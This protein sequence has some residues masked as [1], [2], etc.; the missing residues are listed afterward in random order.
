MILIFLK[1]SVNNRCSDMLFVVV[2]SLISLIYL[3]GCY[4]IL[5]MLKFNHCIAHLFENINITPFLD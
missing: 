5:I 4:A 3:T 2:V 1:A